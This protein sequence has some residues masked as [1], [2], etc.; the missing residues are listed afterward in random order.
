MLNLKDIEYLGKVIK[1]ET[2][3]DVA[4]IGGGTAGFIAA[5]AAARTSAHT[6]V[7]DSLPF[8][9]GTHTGGMVIGSSG[10]RHMTPNTEDLEI[11]FEGEQLVRGIPQEYIDRMLEYGGA[12]GKKGNATTKLAFD[13]EIAKV[14]IEEMVL[15]AGVDIWLLTQLVDVVMEGNRVVGVLV[16]SSGDLHLIKTKA[17]VDSSGD[18]VVCYR[19]GAVC[20]IG[21]PS[22]GRPQA[23]SLYFTLGGVDFKNLLKYLRS[24]PEELPRRLTANVLEERLSEGKPV[25]VPSPPRLY[26]KAIQSGDLP[27]AYGTN[28]PPYSPGCFRTIYRSGRVYPDITT[29]N[30]NM[31]YNVLPDRVHLTQA[32]IASRKFCLKIVDYYRKYVPGFENSYLMLSAPFFGLRETRRIVGDYILTKEDVIEGREFTDAVGRCGI[33]LDV[34]DEAGGEKAGVLIE[35]GGTKG[36]YHVPYRILLPKRV[37]GVLTAGRCVSTDHMAHGSIRQQSG[38]MLTGQAAGAAAALATKLGITPRALDTKLLQETLKEQAV[39]I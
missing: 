19:A 39:I 31:A 20:Q 18:A 15:E 4:V 27:V 26:M 16:T 6:C 2:E 21:R 35:V 5:I 8:L 34:H 11:S 25:F 7:I 17:V 9:G 38:C 33:E 28:R 32:M 12:W 13:P 36:W 10:F 29:H 37:E 24:H 3:S 14:V 1:S 30:M 22:D 23:A